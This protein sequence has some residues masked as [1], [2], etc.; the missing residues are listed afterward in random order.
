MRPPHK[1]LEGYTTFGG[2]GGIRTPGDITATVVFKTTALD[3]SA[4]PPCLF[5]ESMGA[6]DIRRKKAAHSLPCNVRSIR[7]SPRSVKFPDKCLTHTLCFEYTKFL[8][9]ETRHIESAKLATHCVMRAPGSHLDRPCTGAAPLA[10]QSTH[11]P[12]GNFR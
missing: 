4:T 7:S 8:A 10:P 12:A 6:A 1:F 9:V 3:R 2:G 11:R 5:L